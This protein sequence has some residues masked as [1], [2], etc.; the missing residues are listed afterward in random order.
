MTSPR[1]QFF[2]EVEQ[3]L[4]SGTFIALTLTNRAHSSVSLPR[5]QSLRPILLKRTLFIQWEVQV[6]R[7]QTHL[8]LNPEQTLERLKSL[9]GI[10]YRDAGLFTSSGDLLATSN[11]TG[12]RLRRQPPSRL[13]PPAQTHNRQKES[14]ARS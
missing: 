8:N 11:A 10:D 3:S 7:Q 6:D 12:L 13:L 14:P 9:L 2:H 1:D 4:Q 5:K